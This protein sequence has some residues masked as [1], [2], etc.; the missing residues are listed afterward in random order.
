MMLIMQRKKKTIQITLSPLKILLSDQLLIYVDKDL[1]TYFLSHALQCSDQ[2]LELFAT[3]FHVL[4]Q[5]ETGATRAEQ[6]RVASLRHFVASFYALF[7]GVGVAHRDAERV[8]IV[9]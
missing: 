5:V 4:E 1:F 2:C 7:H 9:V 6:H 3:V 8:E